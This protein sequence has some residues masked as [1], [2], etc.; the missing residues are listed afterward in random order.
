MRGKVKTEEVREV[1]EKVKTE[2]V[3]EKG[4]GSDGEAASSGEEKRGG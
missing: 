2:V 3:K 4:R 1:R